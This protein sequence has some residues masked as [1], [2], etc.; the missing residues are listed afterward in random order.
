M[1]C[2]HITSN[3]PLGLNSCLYPRNPDTLLNISSLRGKHSSVLSTS[4]IRFRYFY[5]WLTRLHSRSLHSFTSVLNRSLFNDTIFSE[6]ILIWLDS[7]FK[8]K[9]SFPTRLALRTSHAVSTVASYSGMKSTASRL[10]E[11]HKDRIR[12]SSFHTP[13]NRLAVTSKRRVK[14]ICYK[15]DSKTTILQQICHKFLCYIYFLCSKNLDKNIANVKI[16]NL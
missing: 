12:D 14:V 15:K 4:Y 7:P 1:Y 16:L 5:N 2:N 9:L 8:R 11:K 6:S 10:Q 13:K 3:R